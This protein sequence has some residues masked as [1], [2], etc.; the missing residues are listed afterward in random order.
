MRRINAEDRTSEVH[1]RP[2]NVGA[3][4]SE[5]VTSSAVTTRSDK[6]ELFI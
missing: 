5:D 2:R 1:P 3:T 4:N 6:M